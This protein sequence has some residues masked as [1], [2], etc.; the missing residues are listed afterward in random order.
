MNISALIAQFPV[1]FSIQRNLETIDSVLAQADPDEL[2]IFPEGALSGYAPDISFLKQINLSELAAGIE[3]LRMQAMQRNLNVWAGSCVSRDG[4]WFNTAYGFSAA[5]K[6]D[7]YEKI[8]LANK[9]RGIFTA[10]DHLPLFEWN[11]PEGTVLLG[12]QICRELRYPEQWGWLARRGAQVFLHL[13]NAVGDSTFQ[14]VWKSHLVSR[15]AETQR[16]VL[17]AN[18]AAAEQ[19]S[20]TIAI[21]PEGHILG[22]VVSAE[23]KVLRVKLD[24]SKVSNLYLDQ[25]TF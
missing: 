8:N 7:V 14:P 18:N 11:L 9:E 4:K 10:G 19:V 22:E 13:N 24:L 23:L 12:V 1:S 16:F 17:S 3:H 21:A 20:P 5:G 25:S 15:A 6:I 2:V